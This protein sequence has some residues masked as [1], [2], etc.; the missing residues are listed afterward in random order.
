MFLNR[1]DLEAFLPGLEIFLE[2]KNQREF[3]EF[4]LK[5]VTRIENNIKR[6]HLIEEIQAKAACSLYFGGKIWDKNLNL[7]GTGTIN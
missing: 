5:R 6:V 3:A 2:L 4:R 1:R 7:L